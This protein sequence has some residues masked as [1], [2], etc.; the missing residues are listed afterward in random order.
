MR[1]LLPL[2]ASPIL[3]AAAGQVPPPVVVTTPAQPDRSLVRW[4][5]QSVRCGDAVIP[6]DGVQRPFGALGW[7][8]QPPVQVTLL[9]STDAGGRPL[10]IRRAAGQTSYAPGL[11]DLAPSL[12]ASRL[13]TPAAQP[14]C[15]ITY[16]AQVRTL[17]AADVADLVA[18]SMQ[19]RSERLPPAGFDRIRAQGGDCMQGTRPHVR[20]WTYLDSRTL[21]RTPGRPEWA[22]IA[23]DINVHGRPANVRSSLGTGLA[24]LTEAATAAVREARYYDR[25]RAGCLAPFRHAPGVLRAPTPPEEA[26][27]RPANSTCDDPGA[28]AAPL[29]MAFPANFERRR[30]EGWAM[31]T[32]DVAPWGGL[33]NIRVLASEPSSEFGEAAERG[34]RGAAKAASPA[35]RTGCVDRILYKLPPDAPDAGE[36][37]AP[38]PA[39]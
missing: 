30:I 38:P 13:A 33:G 4:V 8:Q 12:A 36:A 18:F 31:I 16:Q 10:S 20:S 19:P 15:A 25:N 24:P 39:D 29:V 21:P 28:F 27:F 11:E 9:F 32:Y 7:A 6:V 14:A 34:L 1:I 5:P 26:A 23:Y 22:M 2:C 37:D 3:I 35:G 17:A